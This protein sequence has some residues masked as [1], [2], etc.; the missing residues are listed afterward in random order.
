MPTIND[1]K[2]ATLKTL[3][4]TNG[5][6]N[7]LESKWLKSVVAPYVGAIPD[8][9]RKY[10]TNLG[11]TDYSIDQKAMRYL[12]D[13]GYTGSIT[14]RWYQYWKNGGP[15]P[16]ARSLF[17]SGEDGFLFG[18]FAELDELF[19]NSIGTA[20]VSSDGQTVGM[21]LDD[22][23]WA[24]QSYSQIVAAATELRGTGTTELL[25]SATAAT[26][27]TGTGIGSATRVDLGN[28]S[29]VSISVIT[30][31]TYI[32]DVENTGASALNIR[33]GPP[34]GSI[35]QTLSAGVRQTI[36]VQNA[37]SSIT[38]ALNAN[39]S[40][41]TFVVH[42]VKRI[43]GNSAVQITSAN[44]PLW[45]A[46]AGKPYLL[47]DGTNDFIQ[48]PF[49][50]GVAMTLAAACRITTGATFILGGGDSAGNHR[51]F[52]GLEGNG[53]IAGGWGSQST[54]VITSV[55]G[56]LRGQDH[57][58]LMTADAVSVDLYLDGVLVYTGA[59]SGS[60]SGTTSPIAIGANNNG[61]TPASFVTGRVSAALA[62]N[63]RATPAEIGQITSSFRSTF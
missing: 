17:R 29:Y 25:G 41:T 31:G 46:N 10:L 58:L 54:D 38:F 45:K 50:P 39:A 30:N 19:Q 42:S 34:T 61:G 33:Q 22:R 60:P 62:L 20:N 13:L 14:N 44:R 8:M 32:V 51:C 7:T 18:N 23:G 63:R 47:L 35:H 1:Y 24:G 36:I 6:I 52:L 53:K 56:D 57:V 21:A 49:V 28:Q 26:Y 37:T 3:T 5:D 59:P 55:S 40:S 2:K 11:Y 4:G 43:P 16:L 48:D 27:N 15:I 12:G 9:W